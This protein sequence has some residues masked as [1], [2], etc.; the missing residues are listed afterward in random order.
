MD[1]PFGGEKEG[2]AQRFKGAKEGISG[3]WAG[4]CDYSPGKENYN[5]KDG[6]VMKRNF[7]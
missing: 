7:I 6:E 1:P 2:L 4:D 3:R 5:S